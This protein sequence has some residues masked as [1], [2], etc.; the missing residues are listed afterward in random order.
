M[1]MY[2][3]IYAPRTREVNKPGVKATRTHSFSKTKPNHNMP[4]ETIRNYA[5]EPAK[6]FC[7]CQLL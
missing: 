3:L 1:Y 5:N 2:V 4:M 6:S 7:F